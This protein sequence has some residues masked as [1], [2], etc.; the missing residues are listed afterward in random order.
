MPTS[1]WAFSFLQAGMIGLGL[2]SGYSLS[3]RLS[4]DTII[5]KRKSG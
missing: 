1:L 5:S 2:P 3:D 4:P